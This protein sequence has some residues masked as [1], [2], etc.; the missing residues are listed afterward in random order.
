MKTISAKQA[1]RMLRYLAS[2]VTLIVSGGCGERSYMQSGRPSSM[3]IASASES[4]SNNAITKAKDQDKCVPRLPQEICPGTTVD[5][6]GLC[7][8]AT[9]INSCLNAENTTLALPPGRY[10]IKSTIN[11]NYDGITLSTRG[12]SDDVT[13]CLKNS[14]SKPCAVLLAA[15]EFGE[16]A[17]PDNSFE[18]TMLR[19]GTNRKPVNR[20]TIDH[21]AL[22]GAKDA[23]RKN[24]NIT[25]NCGSKGGGRNLMEAGGSDNKL[26]HSASVNALCGTAVGWAVAKTGNGSII[27]NNFIANNGIGYPDNTIWSDGLTIG[28]VSNSTITGNLFQ[29]STDVDV[30]IGGA[31]NTTF[32]DNI[33]YH[34]NL[35]AFAGFMLTNWS[36]RNSPQTAEWADFRGL[37]VSNNIF[38]CN[39]HVQICVQIGIFPWF[40]PETH[41][42]NWSTMGGTF[43]NNKIFT[44][45]QGINVGGGG[46]MNFPVIL[47]GNEIS[48]TGSGT[49]EIGAGS[50]RT[51]RRVGKLNVFGPRVQNFIEYRN[52]QGADVDQADPWH[53]IF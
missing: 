15:D 6:G 26:L 14:T 2:A 45:N 20:I 24:I 48:K 51:S 40:Y 10:L 35:N 8:A 30:V 17:K 18:R 37:V 3:V 31:T 52:G 38:R 50:N 13:T 21:I 9:G 29:D 25:K 19:I 12:L 46:T 39:R 4:H 33:I 49:T 41:W 34:Q 42:A 28:K 16:Q 36:L 43:L 22:D 32:S 44:Q 27:R 11:I 47:D 1:S 7:D 53:S 23:R 5:T